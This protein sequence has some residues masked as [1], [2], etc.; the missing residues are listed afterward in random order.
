MG[1][2]A[3][4]TRPGVAGRVNRLAFEASPARDLVWRPAAGMP[5]FAISAANWRS[6]GRPE[7]LIAWDALARC[8]CE[9]NPFLESWHLLPSLQALDPKGKAPI[10]RLEADGDLAGMVPLLRKR[11]HGRWPLPHLA[12]W[13]HPDAVPTAPLVATGLEPAFWR[14]VLAWAD[15]HAGAALF[16]HLP[17]I[18][19][20]GP[21]HRA[22]ANVLAE[23]GRSA[24][25]VHRRSS[26]APAAD[27]QELRDRLARLSELGDVTF[28]KGLDGEGLDAWIA[29]FLA[30]ESSG[31]KGRA[32]IA[33]AS[34]AETEKLF[35]EVLAAA[36]AQDRLE[37]QAL[38]L[39]GRPIAMAAN[40]LTP[41]GAFSYK[42]A[43][44]ENFARYSPGV[45]L[46]CENL[47]MLDRTDIA[48]TDSCA[49]ADHPMIDHI[50][51][52]RRTI[53]CWSIA[54]GGRV[55]RAI[56]GRLLRTELA[57]NPAG[58]GP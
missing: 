45:L 42:T 26:E 27:R 15:R 53:G 9:P 3:P 55:R 5:A 10:L 1:S 8:A 12:A 46:Q 48:W 16:L 28:T 25:L 52:E 35:R 56:F 34:R 21:L 29:N 44:D 32:G 20:E 37:R 47:P 23:Q 54:I 14:A 13:T 33:L 58:S 38:L 49:A 36:C 50:W 43:F 2:P 41:S 24:A 11:R 31:W 30:L 17:D 39:D 6:F 7:D 18:P 22:L 19:L 4:A 51:R 57:R 40:F